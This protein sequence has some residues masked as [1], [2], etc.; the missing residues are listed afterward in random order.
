MGNV[1]QYIYNNEPYNL[2]L[3]PVKYLIKCP[4]QLKHFIVFNIKLTLE[5][6][7]SHIQERTVVQADV[8]FY[9][10]YSFIT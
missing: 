2:M 4:H 3:M 1:L 7:L 6:T 5:Q 8:L 10:S 9:L